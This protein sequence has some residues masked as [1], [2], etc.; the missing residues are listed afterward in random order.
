MKNSTLLILLFSTLLHAQQSNENYTQLWQEVDRFELVNL[1]KSANNVV[2]AIY[3]KAKKD[4]NTPQLV[5]SLLFQSKFA[6][7]LEEDAQLKIIHNFE[8]EIAT[9]DFPTKNI[10]ESV[11]AN[12]YWQY[13][14]QNRWKFYNRTKSSE[15][16]DPTDFRTWDLK[17]LFKEVHIHFQNSLENGLLAQQI[18]LDNFDAILN[19]APQSKIYRP[20]LYDFLAH[21]ALDFYKT[22]EIHLTKPSYKFEIDNPTYLDNANSFSKLSIET[23]DSLSLQYHALLLFKNLIA[24][25]KKDIDPTA[26]VTLDLKRLY[27]VKQHATFLDKEAVFLQ[28]L[29]ISKE[30]YKTH[31]ISTLYDYEVAS[32]YQQQG[33]KYKPKTDKENQWKIKEAL[34]ICESAISSFP[35]SRGAQKCQV[36]RTNILQSSLTLT[37]EEFIVP[38][39]PAL[40]LVKHKNTDKL[41]L[42]VARISEK[43]REKFQKIYNYKEQLAYLQK[44]KVSKEW[45][46]ELENEDD[47]Q[48]HSTEVVLPKLVQ[49]TYLIFATPDV[50]SIQTFAFTYIQATDIALIDTNSNQQ[51]I[52]QVVDRYYGN[53]IRGAKVHLTN[54]KSGGYSEKIDK[55]FTTNT[56]G[57]VYLPNK[58]YYSNVKVSVTYGDKKGLFGNYYIRKA[59]SNNIKQKNYYQ[60]FLFTD[61]SIYRPGQTLY[62]KGIVVK[63][64]PDGKQTNSEVLSDEKVLINLSDVN[65]QNVGELE[66]LTN[67]FGSVSGEFIVPEGGLTGDFYLNL[68][69]KKNNVNTGISISVEEYKRPKF[70][71]EFQ[72]ITNSFKVNDTVKVTGIATAYAGSAIT[73]AKVV[74]RVHRKVQYPRW[75]YWY[76][77]MHISEPQEISHGETTTDGEGKYDISFEAIPD[78][79]I[80]I[81][82]LPIFQ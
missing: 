11:L 81:A 45:S 43:Q 36:L 7:I 62:F 21:N 22:N 10:L 35:E 23:K 55:V 78:K 41:N 4:E 63:R 58:Q 37:T 26:L 79:S 65:G 30:T 8:N 27:F 80:A 19:Q 13:F 73:E 54:Y 59:Y 68:K 75:W 18:S 64:K 28:T 52:L 48:M 49:G 60:A 14:Q 47:F 6:L 20:T 61:R 46:S 12:L 82:D 38:N 24:F 1:P 40:I 57:Q 69:G 66:L 42:K 5:K 56:F 70:E 77:P 25:H 72:P 76:R 16:V 33:Q 50:D 32:L 44:I 71:T 74:Y 29:L 34:A 39:R 3:K 15:K 51:Q 53:P 31:G 2:D 67:E 9:A 17:T